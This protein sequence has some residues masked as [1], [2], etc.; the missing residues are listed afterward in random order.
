MPPALRSLLEI[1][2]EERRLSLLEKNVNE[3]STE[4]RKLQVEQRLGKFAKSLH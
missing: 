2:G 4:D 3:I 1:G